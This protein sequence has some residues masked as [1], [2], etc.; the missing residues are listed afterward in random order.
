MEKG[1]HSVDVL[2]ERGKKRRQIVLKPQNAGA[3]R[4]RRPAQLFPARSFVR[5]AFSSTIVPPTRLAGH[6]FSRHPALPLFR[7][8]AVGSSATLHELTVT[9][10][11]N[12]GGG[13]DERVQGRM[14]RGRARGPMQPPLVRKRSTSDGR[15]KCTGENRFSTFYYV[16]CGEFSSCFFRAP[17]PRSGFHFVE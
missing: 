7:V 10:D 5:G 12:S 13:G 8:H 9:N 1:A 3:R 2:V 4:R 14:V 15:E 11:Q 16:C 17:L 6:L